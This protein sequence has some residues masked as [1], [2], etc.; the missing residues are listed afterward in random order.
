C[1]TDST[2]TDAPQQQDESAASIETASF[3]EEDQ[4]FS[5]DYPD[6]MEQCMFINEASI[7]LKEDGTVL[8]KIFVKDDITSEFLAFRMEQHMEALLEQYNN[9]LLELVAQL[10]NGTEAAKA[11]GLNGETVS[12][13]IY[14]E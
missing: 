4:A 9:S 1:S 13:E 8:A 11:T 6:T 3:T 2:T 14:I 5:N 7:E 10:D 12:M